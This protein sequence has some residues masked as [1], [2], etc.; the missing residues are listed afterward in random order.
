[1]IEVNFINQHV[2]KSFCVTLMANVDQK[3]N[4]EAI[5]LMH[6]LSHV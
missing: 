2:F 5:E 1:M 3:L 4:F 6:M